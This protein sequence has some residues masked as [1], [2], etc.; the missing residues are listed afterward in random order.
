M[1]KHGR[2]ATFTAAGETR[3]GLVRETGIVD[4]SGRFVDKYPTLRHAIAEGALSRLVEEGERHTP[5]FAMDGITWR[6]P[7]PALS[8]CS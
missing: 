6:P 7:V 1:S 4:L 5:D 8:A 3:Y 2:L